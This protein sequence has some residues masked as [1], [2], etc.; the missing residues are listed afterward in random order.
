MTWS[1]PVCRRLPRISIYIAE[2]QNRLQRHA[3]GAVALFTAVECECTHGG[4]VNRSPARPIGAWVPSVR[5]APGPTFTTYPRARAPVAV[6]SVRELA[7]GGHQSRTAGSDSL[8]AVLCATHRRHG[9]RVICDEPYQSRLCP[10]LM[11][12]APLASASQIQRFIGYCAE[13]LQTACFRTV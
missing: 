12:T 1:S 2:H 9:V 4:G 3:C 11:R 13:R 8:G 7:S 6:A 10:K 5:W